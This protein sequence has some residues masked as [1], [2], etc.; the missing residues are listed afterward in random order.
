MKNCARIF[1]K[2]IT[3][4]N[5]SAQANSIPLV[6]NLTNMYNPSSTMNY[7]INLT[8]SYSN[9][10][11]ALLTTTFNKT[12]LLDYPFNLLNYSSTLGKTSLVFFSLN[13]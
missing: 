3:C 1:D 2:I 12:Q 13:T 6:F 9:G 7:T 4:S 11:K 5:V 8:L 10:S